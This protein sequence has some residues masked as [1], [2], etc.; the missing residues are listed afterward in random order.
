MARMLDRHNTLAASAA[1]VL[2]VGETGTGKALVARALHDRGP[3][4]CGRFVAVPCAA[5][6]ETALEAAHGGT[7]L[8]GEVGDLSPAHQLELLRVLSVAIDVRVIATTRRDLGQLVR[9]GRFRADL[10]QR[11]N[12]LRVDVPPLRVREGDL[13]LLAQYFLNRFHRRGRAPA[14]MSPD[15]WT[16]LSAFGFPGNVRQLGH[17]IEHAALLAGDGEIEARH[18]PAEITA[19]GSAIPS[20]P[21]GLR[22]APAT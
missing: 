18:L 19:A 6:S 21:A 12:A 15:A 22:L 16:A 11:L 3:R 7:L 13:P 2:V 4:H 17:A 14:R 20:P 1:P 5:F 10:Y 9:D 8:L